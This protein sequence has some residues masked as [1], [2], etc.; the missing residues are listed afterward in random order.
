MSIEHAIAEIHKRWGQRAITLAGNLP[1]QSDRLPTGLDV[2]DD[3]L[4]GGIL[5]GRFTNFVG[6]PTSGATTL[7][8]RIIAYL[9][10]QGAV[11]VYIDFEQTF[12]GG[13]AYNCGVDLQR[14][15]IVQP[16]DAVAALS[17]LRDIAVSR[18]VDLVVMD[19][20]PALTHLNRVRLHQTAAL[21]LSRAAVI[22]S[23]IRMK[24]HGWIFD[25][26]DVIGCHV[27]AAHHNR[28]VRFPLHFV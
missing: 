6:V 14:L 26:R 9:N 24:R 10:Q 12:N 1:P 28:W 16:P 3:L 11:S 18:V 13:Y 7:A 5:R 2:L 23:A 17:L 22:P 4:D 15:L 20:T 19:S 21:V 27:E 8:L 25:G